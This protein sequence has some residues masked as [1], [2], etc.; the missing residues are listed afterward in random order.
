VGRA[1]AALSRSDRFFHVLA[2]RATFEVSVDRS[3]ALPGQ[4][5]G[6]PPGVS[7]LAS[8]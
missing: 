2:G 6:L 5:T 1:D 7:A 3:L 8:R 4:S